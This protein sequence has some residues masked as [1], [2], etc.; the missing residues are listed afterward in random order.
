MNK[1]A[2]INLMYGISS[3]GDSTVFNFMS[4]YSLY[5][6]TDVAGLNPA[7]A[8]AII[9]FSNVATALLVAVIGYLSD[10]L[11]L[12]HGRRLPYMFAAIPLLAAAVLMMFGPWQ[13]HGKAAF[14]FYTIAVFLV[15]AGHALYV[16][17]YEAL[18]AELV[19]D[20]HGRTVLRS[21]ARTFQNLGSL[22]GMV[23]IMPVIGLFLNMGFS[24]KMSWMLT[25]FCA[26]TPAALLM[27]Y[28]SVSLYYAV[29]ELKHKGKRGDARK[30][31]SDLIGDYVQVVRIRE[32]WYLLLMTFFFTAAYMFV[33]SSIVYFMEYNLGLSKGMESAVFLAFVVGAIVL[34]P[35]ITEAARRF[36][37]KGAVLGSFLISGASLFALYFTGV[38]SLLLL[39]VHIVL[40]SVGSS[41]Y[42]QVSYSLVY[43]ISEVDEIRNGKRR[44][45]VIMSVSKI[46]L[47]ISTAVSV[48]VL[49]LVMEIFHYDQTASVQ[50]ESALLGFRVSMT[51][52]PA[53]LFLAAALFL[54]MYPVSGKTHSEILRQLDTRMTK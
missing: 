14:V 44:E 21:Y 28:T 4:L 40:F 11:P 47:R 17:P 33:K 16:V 7:A 27:L 46:V 2:R 25:V 43:D 22:S 24:D 53:I 49:A 13:L 51:L 9:L 34:T 45:A 19:Q 18:G 8:G 12:K 52:V 31:F 30:G 37:K 35:F 26:I 23:L 39:F 29:P 50:P 48:Q 32:F 38:S 15:W 3:F 42:W 6:L 20:A 41:G 10:T 5:F 54:R 1:E 36:E